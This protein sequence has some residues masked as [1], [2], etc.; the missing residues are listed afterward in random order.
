MN[1][2]LFKTRTLYAPGHFG[3]GY[4]MMG[5]NEF[6]E[7][8]SEWKTWGFNEYSDWFDPVNCADPYASFLYD[9]GN[10]QV[11]A[12]KRRFA[13][14]QEMGLPCVLLITPNMVFQEQCLPEVEAVKAERIFGQLVCPSIP[15]GREI[16]LRNH[17]NWFRDLAEAGVTLH[18]LTACPYDFGGCA[19][20]QCNPWIITFAEL[21]REIYAVAEKYH[22]GIEMRMV[23]W[24]W[25]AEEHR[26]FAEWADAHAPGWV[27]SIAQHIPY[28][29][30]DVADVPLPKGCERQ[31]FVHISYAEE[32]EPRDV[33]GHLGPVIAAERLERT[34]AALHAQG[35]TGWMAYT[36]GIYDDVNKALVAQISSGKQSSGEGVLTDYAQRYLGAS[37]GNISVWVSWLR[38]WGIPYD[39][40]TQKAGEQLVALRDD[41][42]NEA[43]S[44]WRFKQWEGKSQLLTK[45]AAVMATEPDSTAREQ[46]IANYWTVHEKLMR[47][48]YRLGLLRVIF[49]RPS[50]PCPWMKKE[51]L[52][53]TAKAI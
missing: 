41:S 47:D 21:S 1:T 12:K 52:S 29:D 23:G 42:D 25:Q 3:N 24:W 33:Y 16:I 5:E 43:T 40:D 53:S 13:I 38:S 18:A 48:V 39:V 20:D 9:F 6:R 32:S 49:G 15:A 44:S 50:S 28:T 45:S 17:E 31:A 35:C 37:Q 22:P 46:A 4:E 14:A 27:K 11:D 30:S 8:L 10:A 26:F 34:L 19:C 36:E 51:P 2:P 7:H